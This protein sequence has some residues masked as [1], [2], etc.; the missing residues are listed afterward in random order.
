MIR[1]KGHWHRSLQ[2]I[3]DKCH[4]HLPS[5]LFFCHLCWSLFLFYRCFYL[6]LL[7]LL[8]LL[9][10]A[11]LSSSQR[12]CQ[13]IFFMTL[14]FAWNLLLL[15][16]WHFVDKLSPR[17]FQT[18]CKFLKNSVWWPI[19][20]IPLWHGIYDHIFH[21]YYSA[22]FIS[23]HFIYSSDFIWN[24]FLTFIYLIVFC[25]NEQFIHYT[26]KIR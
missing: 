12:V 11:Q 24:H 18:N 17:S 7:L 25:Y 23:R 26:W 22:F 5:L 20:T 3:A 6:Q 8:L 21:Y 1:E 15:L 9:A 14:F 16:L 4:L 2:R 19:Y 10:P 13:N